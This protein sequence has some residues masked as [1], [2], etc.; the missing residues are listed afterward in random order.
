M[1]T[2]ER[3]RKDKLSTVLWKF[4]T[5]MNTS[6]DRV[7]MRVIFYGEGVRETKRHKFVY[8]VKYDGFDLRKSTIKECPEIPEDVL[9]EAISQVGFEVKK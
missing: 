6:T 3:M 1:I 4:T 9:Q 8:K 5:Y 7:T 2:V